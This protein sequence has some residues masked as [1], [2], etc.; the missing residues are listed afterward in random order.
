MKRF[1]SSMVALMM[2][3]AI[4]GCGGGDK[5]VGTTPGTTEIASG[6]LFEGEYMTFT[7]S[8]DWK[9]AEN[10][11]NKMINME[12]RTPAGTLYILVK[13]EKDNWRT[14]EEAVSAFADNYGGSPAELINYG[15]YD[16]YQTTFEHGGAQTM[17]VT[18]I[19]D[20]KVTITLQGKDHDNDSS[21]TNILNSIELNF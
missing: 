15:G 19:D 12:K 14:A 3:F 10:T 6:T 2:A 1:F 8:N 17:L 13:A 16:F 21:I 7:H 20:N 11:Q 9:I 5:E 18:K 4:I